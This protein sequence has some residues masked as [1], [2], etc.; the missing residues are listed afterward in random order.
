MLVNMHMLECYN[1][2]AKCIKEKV[3]KNNFNNN[4]IENEGN[5]IVNETENNAYAYPVTATFVKGY[6]HKSTMDVKIPSFYLKKVIINEG[7]EEIAPS[8]LA[9][10]EK[11]TTIQFPS[12]LKE[13]GESAFEGCISLKNIYLPEGVMYIYKY[14]FEGCIFI[15]SVIIPATVTAIGDKAFQNCE[16]LKYFTVL[17]PE[18]DISNIGLPAGCKIIRPGKEV[19]TV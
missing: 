7:I 15:E 8:A 17:N 11:L 13:I 16:N 18:L 12:T 1:F 4:F 9:F 19:E 10:S 5:Y 3:M 6:F 14:A 2:F